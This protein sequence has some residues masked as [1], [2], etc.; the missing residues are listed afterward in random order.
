RL[1]RGVARERHLHHAALVLRQAG[2]RGV[3]V[4]RL[5]AGRK[6]HL[7]PEHGV[8][9]AR[10]LEP[11]VARV[12]AVDETAHVVEVHALAHV[13]VRLPGHG[14]RR[15]VARPHLALARIGVRA[16]VARQRLPGAVGDALERAVGARDLARVVARAGGVAHAQ[17]VRLRLVVARVL[18]HE[19][20]QG[21][22]RGA[23]VAA[24]RRRDGGGDAQ[25][26]PGELLLRDL[27]RRVPRGDVTDLVA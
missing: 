20:A 9:E 15:E 21:L 13:Q 2:G 12:L 19:Q 4:L 16:H 23:A 22:L 3:R 25:P 14:P 6:A 17:L 7:Q 24:E 5:P 8:V 11:A 1:A 18:E 27:L 26:Q 10:A